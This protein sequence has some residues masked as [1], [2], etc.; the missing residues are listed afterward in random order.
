MGFCF[1]EYMNKE[2]AST[3]VSCLN[4]SK[5]DRRIIRVDWDI[6]FK[7]G[8]QFGRGR[9]GGQK[10]DSVRYEYEKDEEAKNVPE[11]IE[12]S[13][14]EHIKAEQSNSQLF[15]DLL[16]EFNIKKSFK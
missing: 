16:L 6:G 13:D 9:G 12:V 1:V 10:R 15:E 7:E 3:A 11:T 14:I 5:L 4:R 8:R 2:D